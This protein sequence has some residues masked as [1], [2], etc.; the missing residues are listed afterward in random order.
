MSVESVA[1]LLAA[2]GY[3]IVFVAILLDCAGLPLPGELVLVT[4]GGMAGTGHLNPVLG[5]AVA[6][7]AA[8]IGDSISYSAGR[9]G[10]DRILARLRLRNRFAPGSAAVVFGRFV[11]GA[12]IALAPL[13]GANRMP[14]PRFL[15][16]DAIG[17]AVWAGVF[18]FLGYGLRIDLGAI[19]RHWNSVTF[20]VEITLAIAIGAYLASKL[21]R[22]QPV[23]A[24]LAVA[25]IGTMSLGGTRPFARDLQVMA[26]PPGPCIEALRGSQHL[27]PVAC[28]VGLV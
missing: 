1:Q 23:R 17:A 18:V 9:L 26:P 15:L 10:G 3:V 28:A 22:L 27:E 11:V 19:Q 13:A 4:L 25:L 16:L 20:G 12:R 24:W 7:I 2:Y 8:L 14:L 5:L 21:A 6:V